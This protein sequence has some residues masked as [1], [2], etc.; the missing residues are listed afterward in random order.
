MVQNL[1]QNPADDYTG[2]VNWRVRDTTDFMYKV[3]K[4]IDKMVKAKLVPPDWI[5]SIEINDYRK[6]IKSKRY[7]WQYVLFPGQIF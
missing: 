7:F 1:Q 2:G 5:D 3:F 4:N 6:G